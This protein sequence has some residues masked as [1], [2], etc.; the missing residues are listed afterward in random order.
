M[1]RLLGSGVLVV[2]TLFAIQLQATPDEIR[3]VSGTLA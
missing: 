1:K 2:T 3:I